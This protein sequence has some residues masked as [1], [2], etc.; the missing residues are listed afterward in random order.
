V[1]IE[2]VETEF[3]RKRAINQSSCNKDF[4]CVEGFCPSFVTVHGGRLRRKAASPR[5]SLP[6]AGELPVPDLPAIRGS[7]GLLVAGIGG[8]G[9]VTIGQLLGMAAHLEGK[10]VT[11]L[12]VT[13]LAQKNGAVM[14]FVR[15]A[16]PGEPLYA[17]RIGTAAADAVLGCDVV[18][19]AGRE[20]LARM[21][22]ARTRVVA[23][24][25]STPTADFTRNPDWK[26]P[27]GGMEAAIVDAVGED[28]AW[29]VDGTRLAT[30]LLGDAIAANLFMLGFAWQRGLVPVSDAAIERAID[31]NDVA[32]E[33]NKAAFA[34]GRVAAVDPA[35][36]EAAVEPAGTP[37]VARR[38]STSLDE[39][40]ARRVDELAEYQD[41]R[42]ARRYAALV[43]RVR[44]AERA[45]VGEAKPSFTEA[46]ARNLFRLM[47]YKDEYEVARLYT[48]G[49]FLERL[50]ERFEGDFRLGFHLAP[51]LLARRN[52]KGE[53][54]KREYGPWVFKAFALLAR[55]RRL[56]GTAFDPFGRSAERRME[57]RL[58]ADYE[59][60]VERLLDA[61]D[62]RR[63]PLATQIASIPEEIRGFGHVKE[64]NLKAALA[65]RQELF[66]EYFAAREAVAA[67]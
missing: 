49:E 7:Y 36:V 2:P 59:A 26:F 66:E 18:V 25:A 13:G 41:E 50:N 34:W 60:D 12:D 22:A 56:R 62:A 61:L 45:L 65:R 43:E 46:V 14:S 64:R 29:F 40:V 39:I 33:Q 38:L 67:H 24:V 35:R 58:I 27:L 4:S 32:I 17:P 51:P 31:L 30:A 47:A 54:V 48:S 19:T 21:D 10:G 55:L 8:T 37:P 6:A 9:V 5:A 15:F 28:R 44:A 23:N 3:G 20:A 52:A 11:V 53:L 42:Y 57:R 16:E 1:S 63:L